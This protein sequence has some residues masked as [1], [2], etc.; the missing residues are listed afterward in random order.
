[1]KNRY[2]D[3]TLIVRESDVDKEDKIKNLVVNDF[4]NWQK[5]NLIKKRA[6]S[7]WGVYLSQG[8]ISITLIGLVVWITKNITVPN[9]NGASWFANN[10][11]EIFVYAFLLLLQCIAYTGFLNWQLKY[12]LLLQEKNKDQIIPPF[13]RNYADWEWK[14]EGIIFLSTILGSVVLGVSVYLLDNFITNG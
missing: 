11:A 6:L 9:E 7:F 3:K 5:G 2:Y 4:E 14:I 10:K 8:S 13:K 1:M 12:S